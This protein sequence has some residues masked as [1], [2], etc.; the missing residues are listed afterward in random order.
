V[1]TRQGGGVRR[2]CVGCKCKPLENREIIFLDN[3]FA[4]N[5]NT[6]KLYQVTSSRF[7]ATDAT[8]SPDGSRLY[9]ADYSSKGYSIVSAEINPETWQEFDPLTVHRWELAVKM[10]EQE[11]FTFKSTDV[12]D[13]AYMIK[14]YRKGLNLFN[15]HSWAPLSF[16]IENKEAYPG[17]MIMSQNLLGSS[18]LSLGYAYDMNEETGKYY[19]K[20]TYQGFYPALDLATDYGLRRDVYIDEADSTQVSYKYN[21]LNFSAGL[22]V[23]LNW[24]IK[25]WRVG[26]Q[27][28]TGYSLNFLKMVPGTEKEFEHDRVN[29]LDGYLYFNASAP[30]SY[31][32]LQPKWGQNVQLNFRDSPFDSERPDRIFAAQ[33][34]IYFPGFAKHHGFKFYGGYQNR[35][36]DHYR[37]S[38][39][40]VIPRGLSEIYS[41]HAFSGSVDY[42]APL[43][44]PDWNIGPVFYLKRIRAAAFY[45]MMFDFDNSSSTIFQSCGLDITFNFHL[46]RL[47]VPIEAGL[48]TIYLPEKNRFEYQFIY[49]VNMGDLY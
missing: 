19:L 31:R 38:G 35:Q 3:I 12:P 48:R 32:D 9:F 2:G 29:S 25:S 14:P 18:N 5:L 33:A 22:R 11:G 41:N 13:S 34:L 10:A 49:Y 8:V 17:V 47:F 16:D 36:V 44:Y 26:V 4:L 43:V 1:A 27:P 30:L 46:F 15:F 24:N 23:P 6:K 28:Y 7:G 40:I 39:F 42:V 20:Y 37:Y 21:E 45:D